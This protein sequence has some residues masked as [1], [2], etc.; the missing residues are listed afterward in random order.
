MR[1]FFFSQEENTYEVHRQG[2]GRLKFFQFPFFLLCTYSATGMQVFLLML[3]SPV[4]GY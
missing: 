3:S 1:F 2:K 4:S